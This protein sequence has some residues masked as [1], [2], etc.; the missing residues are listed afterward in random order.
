MSTIVV[1]R[2]ETRIAIV[3]DTLSVAGNTKCQSNYVAAKDKIVRFQDSYIGIVGSTAHATVLLSIMRKYPDRLC[4]NSVEDIFESYL[5]LHPILKDEFYLRP[6]EKQDDPYE[7]S[8]IDAL[9]AN[10]YG[11]FGMF[12]W[13]EVEEYSRFW[14]IGSGRDYALGAMYSAYD[15]I[16]D[17]EEIARLAVTASCEFDD[18]SGLPYTS[19]AVDVH[20]RAKKSKHHKESKKG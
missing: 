12:S 18:A 2:K 20:R 17:P 6:E 13:R 19:Y 1:V 8:Q 14:A 16:A 4:F 10:P 15:R 9:I 5:K 11:I 7:S 3:A